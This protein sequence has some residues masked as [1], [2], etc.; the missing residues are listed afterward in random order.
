[1]TP[2]LF[3]IPVAIASSLSF[4]ENENFVA[5]PSF[6]LINCVKQLRVLILV[7]IRIDF[8]DG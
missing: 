4:R 3:A 1:M 2:K 6:K 7:G 8:D 5:I